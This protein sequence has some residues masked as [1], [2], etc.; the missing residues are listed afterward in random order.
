MVNLEYKT[1]NCIQSEVN[2]SVRIEKW[3][4]QRNVSTT[5][6]CSSA[7][8]RKHSVAKVGEMY[9]SGMQRPFLYLC[10]DCLKKLIEDGESILTELEADKVDADTAAQAKAAD[11]AANTQEQ[12]AAAD[13]ASVPAE[14]ASAASTDTAPAAPTQGTSVKGKGNA[15]K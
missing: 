13:D 11:D 8:C 7:D 10:E 3:G 14:T 15:K 2:M 5:P 1:N 4:T 6:I 12:N 9:T